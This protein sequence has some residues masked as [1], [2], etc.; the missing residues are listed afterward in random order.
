MGRLRKCGGEIIRGRC[1]NG[2]GYDRFSFRYGGKRYRLPVHRLVAKH[3]VG[4]PMGK[5]QIN[6]IDGNKLNNCADN[7][8]WCT[9]E[10]NQMHAYK[11]RLCGKMPIA[12][13]QFTLD[14][15][16]VGEWESV[17][18]AVLGGYGY[19]SGILRCCRGELE[20]CGGYKWRL[21][22]GE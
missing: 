10:E 20:Q 3:F 9:N 6:H 11:N 18:K 8:E 14:G 17:R 5:E 2:D 22:N 4:N 12:I 16:F 15:N 1:V 19:L 21:K 13:E 7:L